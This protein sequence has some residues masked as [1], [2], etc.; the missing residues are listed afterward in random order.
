VLNQKDIR[1]EN[2]THKV[3]C[4]DCKGNGYRRDCYDEIYQC[5]SCKSQGEI[6][7]TEEEMLENIDDAGMTV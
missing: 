5:K 6:T 4:E 2:K 3:I 1:M 7:F